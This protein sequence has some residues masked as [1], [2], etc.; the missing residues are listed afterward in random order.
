MGV[1]G[2]ARTNMDFEESEDSSEDFKLRIR[3]ATNI[4]ALTSHSE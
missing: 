1:V 4:L 3:Q 2:E